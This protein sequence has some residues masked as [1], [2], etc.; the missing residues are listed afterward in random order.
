MMVSREMDVADTVACL[1]YY[2]GWAD[3]VCN[4][5][6]YHRHNADSVCRLR[7]RFV[8]PFPTSR[9]ELNEISR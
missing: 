8:L 9:H 6:P 4:D 3:K 1:R 5:D 2:A 7:G